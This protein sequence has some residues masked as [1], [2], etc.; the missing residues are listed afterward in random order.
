MRTMGFSVQTLYIF[1]FQCLGCLVL[2][3]LVIKGGK[4]QIVQN[5]SVNILVMSGFHGFTVNTLNR[6]T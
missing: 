3:V 4:P 5:F 6:W 2:T 1:Q